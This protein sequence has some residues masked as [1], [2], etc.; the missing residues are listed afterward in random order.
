MEVITNVDEM[1]LFR[2]QARASGNNV[3]CVPTLGSLHDG[4]CSLIRAAAANQAIV[5]TSVF[6]NPTQ[7][8]SQ[9]DFDKY[10]RDLARDVRMAA[11][12]GSTVVFAPTQA[13]MYPEGGSSIVHVGGI[14]APFEGMFRPG[15][16]DGV[17]TVVCKLFEAIQPDA[18]YFGLKDFQQTL[19]VR[20]M[21]A[22]LL[23]PVDICLMPTLRE[24]NGLAMSSRN[25]RLTAD[26]RTR[27]GAIHAAL[28]LGQT[29]ARAGEL[30]RD[31]YIR[32]M[33]KVLH[34]ADITDVDYIDVAYASDLRT[35]NAFGIGD[36]I[37]LLAAV[38]MRSTRLIDNIVERIGVS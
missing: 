17:A 5:V 31:E 6:V 10:P 9:D 28:T 35:P 22:D 29:M 34:E 16:F 13:E 21:V 27:A 25:S 24:S 30:R 20:R 1:R 15:H 36:E 8:G 2:R 18:A 14:T 32:A 19:V 38:R 12:A 11:S 26:E 37:V 23:M 3:H 4:H 33:T 7:F